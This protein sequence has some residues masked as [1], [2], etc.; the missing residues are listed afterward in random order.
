MT[1]CVVPYKQRIVEGLKLGK[2]IFVNVLVRY[3]S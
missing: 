1:D 2:S 3:D